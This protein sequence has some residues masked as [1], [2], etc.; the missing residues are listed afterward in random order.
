MTNDTPAALPITIRA[1]LD[2]W[3]VSIEVTTAPQ[4][5]GALVKR[6]AQLG[7][8]PDTAPTAA[9]AAPRRAPMPDVVYKPDGTACCP[10][11]MTPLRQGQ[12]GYYCATKE[13]DP[14][15]SNPKGYCR[16]TAKDI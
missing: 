16:F 2:G 12:H 10:W 14:E 6:L 4:H 9:P 7:Y 11:H 15:R 13:S 8:E 5:I 3:P 1:R